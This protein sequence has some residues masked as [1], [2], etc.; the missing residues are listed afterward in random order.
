MRAPASAGLA[1][2]RQVTVDQA[3]PNRQFTDRHHD[4]RKARGEIVSGSRY[5]PHAG[6]IPPRQYAEA[7][8]FY[9]A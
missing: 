8:V 9:L 7:I 2:T 1:R 6:T 3:R 4:E 5:E